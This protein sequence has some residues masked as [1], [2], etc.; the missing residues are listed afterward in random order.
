MPMGEVRAGGMRVVVPPRVK[1]R[2][3]EDA[4]TQTVVEEG[5]KGRTGG[6]TAAERGARACREPLPAV[7]APRVPRLAHKAYL[8]QPL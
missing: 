7:G 3:R 1:G 8:T 5:E 4:S 6:G 2:R